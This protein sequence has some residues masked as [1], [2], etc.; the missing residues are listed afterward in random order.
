MDRSKFLDGTP[1]AASPARQEDHFANNISAQTTSVRRVHE[2]H[3]AQ[4]RQDA[5]LALGLARWRP[6]KRHFEKC[7]RE[8]DTAQQGVH[9]LDETWVCINKKGVLSAVF[10]NVVERESAMPSECCANFLGMRND[11]RARNT[12]LYNI[13]APGPGSELP[14][15]VE[16]DKARSIEYRLPAL[17]LPGDL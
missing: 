11:I 10:D 5:S 2:P 17:Q 6:S 8:I 3:H 7:S 15:G 12:D 9:R 13:A 14:I 4:S 16:S 1:I